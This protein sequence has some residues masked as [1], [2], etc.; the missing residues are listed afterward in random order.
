MTFKPQLVRTFNNH[1]PADYSNLDTIQ[2]FGPSMT[3]Q[4]QAEEAD[5]NTIVKRFGLGGTVPLNPRLPILSDFDEIFDFKTAQDAVALANSRFMSMPAN[6]RSEFQNDPQLFVE[7][8]SNPDN[9]PELRKLGLAPEAPT[10]S[11]TPTPAP[12]PSP[13]PKPPG[14]L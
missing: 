6:I 3:Q 14:E 1:D 5:I 2:N 10:P 8:C 4:S 9:L 12:A 13:A 7:Y 11:P